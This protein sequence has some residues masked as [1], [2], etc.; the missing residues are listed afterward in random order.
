METVI[1]L[2]KNQNNNYCIIIF[3]IIKLN[4]SN[5]VNSLNRSTALHNIRR[6]CPSL[7]T[8]LINTYGHLFDLYFDGIVLHSAEGTTQG[9]PLAMTMYAIATIPLVYSLRTTQ[10]DVSQTW[11]ADDAYASGK[12]DQLYSWWEHL[13]IEGPK[14]EYFPNASKTWLVTKPDHIFHFVC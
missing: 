9:D 14:F 4:F 13:S 12:I 10:K 1:L 2:F 7:A 3:F 5:A 8:I 11:Y 6:L